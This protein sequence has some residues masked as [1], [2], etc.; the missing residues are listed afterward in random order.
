MFEKVSVLLESIMI[1]FLL[2]LSTVFSVS[3]ALASHSRVGSVASPVELRVNKFGQSLYFTI[4]NQMQLMSDCG[5]YLESMSWDRQATLKMNVS[6]NP[7]FV[8]RVGR[9]Q[10]R[11]VW[12]LPASLRG[13]N[14]L[15]VIL[16]GEQQFEVYLKS[17][18]GPVSFKELFKLTD[19]ALANTPKIEEGSHESR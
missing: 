10:V 14:T 15:K 16:N 12:P 3:S 9:P 18:P 1:P 13:S 6:A 17:V 5:L 8:D 4:Q 19:D 7:C 2:S 11:W